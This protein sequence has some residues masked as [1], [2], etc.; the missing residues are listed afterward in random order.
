M[1]VQFIEIVITR[2]GL[3]SQAPFKAK[4][5]IYI[6]RFVRP[7]VGDVLFVPGGQTFLSHRRGGTNIFTSRGDKYFCTEGVGD[8]HSG[9]YDDVDEEM[10]VRI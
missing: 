4:S 5:S 7:S 9:A 3:Q 1:H 6:K 10:V 2:L 8:K